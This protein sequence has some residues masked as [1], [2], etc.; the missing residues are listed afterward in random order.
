MLMSRALALHSQSQLG[1]SSTA[2]KLRWLK[3]SQPRAHRTSLLA[4]G[5]GRPV[6]RQ[7]SWGVRCGEQPFPANPRQAWPPG[8]LRHPRR[9]AAQQF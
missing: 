5:H 1:S 4:R 7:L 3:Y 9:T 2:L 6:R 8:R